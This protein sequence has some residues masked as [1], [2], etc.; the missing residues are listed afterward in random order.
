MK[1]QVFVRT[2]YSLIASFAL[3]GP[4]YAQKQ[5]LNVALTD[6]QGRPIPSVQLAIRGYN[7]SSVTDKLGRAHVP[8][9]SQV[10][11][12]NEVELRIIRSPKRLV[13][14]SPWDGRVR[15][16]L[17]EKALSDLVRVVLSVQGSRQM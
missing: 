5:F 14:I 2:F 7:S 13:F 3:C 16:T 8:L 1:T 4:V 6:L 11:P 17:F 9:S 15:V 12:K 10:N